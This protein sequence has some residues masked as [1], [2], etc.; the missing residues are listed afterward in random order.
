MTYVQIPVPEEHVPAVLE[1]VLARVRASAPVEAPPDPVNASSDDDDDGLP[2]LVT[3]VSDEARVL[4]KAV[5]RVPETRMNY[6]KLGEVSGVRNVGAALQSLKIQR[7]RLN[8]ASP[9]EKRRDSK[10][11][12]RNIYWMSAPTSARILRIMEGDR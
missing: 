2:G 9:I 6:E 10:E 4:L 1:F 3:A 8:V 7:T 12:G 11:D 5:A